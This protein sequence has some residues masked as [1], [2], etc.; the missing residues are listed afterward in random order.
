MPDRWRLRWRP[1]QVRR[2]RLLEDGTEETVSLQRLRVKDRVRVAMG[3]ALDGRLELGAMEAD[4]SVLTGESRPTPK[5][6]GDDLVGNGVNLA[7]PR[8]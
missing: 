3:A 7:K 5:K 1:C 4:G 2:C 6:V 8:H